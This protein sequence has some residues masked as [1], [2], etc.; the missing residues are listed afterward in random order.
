MRK[1]EEMKNNQLNNSLN[2]KINKK[3]KQ[4]CPRSEGEAVTEIL[5]NVGK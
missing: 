1:N 4:T 2:E 5:L 3:E